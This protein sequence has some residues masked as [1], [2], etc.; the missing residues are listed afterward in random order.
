MTELREYAPQIS[1]AI[2][3]NDIPFLRRF[4]DAY[5]ERLE[6]KIAF[7]NWLNTAVVFGTIEAVRFFVDKGLDLNQRHEYG[8]ENSLSYA[9]NEG[10][11]EKVEFL[12]G[13]G[14]EL[15]TDAST[16]NPLICAS[17]SE[18]S[19][20][21]QY[22]LELGLDPKQNY[23]DPNEPIWSPLVMARLN[24]LMIAFETMVQWLAKGDEVKA[25]RIRQETDKEC[26]KHTVAND[27]E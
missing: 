15:F 27:Q 18:N 20:L 10:D 5:P 24:G 6:V 16:S 8:K 14:A 21:I 19:E 3:R 4:F 7:G 2:K 12:Y 17:H 13:V 1:D 22:L 26:Q 9:C 25:E 11:L 23:S